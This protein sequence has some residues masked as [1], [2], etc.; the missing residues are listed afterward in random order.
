MPRDIYWGLYVNSILIVFVTCYIKF[1]LKD[2]F[3]IF[4][5]TY[6]LFKI[7]ICFVLLNMSANFRFHL[8][9]W[10]DKLVN[11]LFAPIASTEIGRSKNFHSLTIWFNEKTFKFELNSFKRDKKS[12]F[13]LQSKNTVNAVSGIN[14]FCECDWFI[15]FI[16]SLALPGVTF[17]W[18]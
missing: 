3:F 14:Y 15:V 12:S 7:L 2:P 16:P 17:L 10:L 13:Y 5:Q 1:K 11:F 6:N 9:H 4:L 18:C 8:D